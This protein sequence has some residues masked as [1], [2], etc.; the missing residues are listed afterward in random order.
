MM[1]EGVLIEAVQDAG[2]GLGGGV[3]AD[4]MIS[5]DLA[6]GTYYVSIGGDQNTSDVDYNLESEF[7]E[8]DY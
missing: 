6:A 8:K 5:K 2:D 7:E 1:S 3:A 4:F